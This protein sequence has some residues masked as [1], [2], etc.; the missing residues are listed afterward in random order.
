MRG[1]VEAGDT[2]LRASGIR[3]RKPDWLKIRLSTSPAYEQ[4]KGLIRD[5]RLHT[6][7]QE[8]QCPNMAH[9]FER[10]TATFLLLGDTCTRGCRFCAVK[11]GRPSLPDPE[12]PERVAEAAKILGLKHVVLTSVTRDDLPDGGAG[13]FAETVRRIRLR[14]KPISIEVLIP[15]FKGSREALRT[16]VEAHPEV[17]NHNVETVPRLY[18]EVRPQ[19]KY[20]RSLEVIRWVK[21]EDPTITSKSGLMAGLGERPEEVL[22]VMEDLRR[23]NCN[24]MTIGQYLAPSPLHHPVVEYVEPDQFSFYK[25]EGLARGFSSIASGPLVRSSF[26]AGESYL[27]ARIAK[28]A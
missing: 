6:V 2:P 19:A 17:I 3:E 7:C 13:Y 24:I 27:E 1:S 15:D 28:G 22:G 26:H 9:C 18:R 4:V 23:A 11:S 8:A 5:H 12:E 10:R 16:L 20:E 25:K 21:D 14:V